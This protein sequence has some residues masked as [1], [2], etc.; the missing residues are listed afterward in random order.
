MTCALVTKHGF[1]CI[2][3]SYEHIFP[4]ITLSTFFAKLLILSRSGESCEC[5]IETPALTLC[6]LRVLMMESAMT[7]GTCH[8]LWLFRCPCSTIVYHLPDVVSRPVDG[9]IITCLVCLNM[10]SSSSWNSIVFVQVTL[11][12]IF[13]YQYI[14]W[15]VLSDSLYPM[16]NVPWHL[17]SSQIQAH[18]ILLL[19]HLCA[20]NEY[21]ILHIVMHILIICQCVNNG[22][23]K[24]SHMLVFASY[25]YI[26]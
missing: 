18:L 6:T 22:Q 12:S 15:P 26:L 8:C 17:P 10:S 2:Q 13:R 4:D 20:I 25:V 11:P 24:L 5:I 1:N 3:I 21:Y 23:R 19:F 7:H 9:V 14:D 16:S